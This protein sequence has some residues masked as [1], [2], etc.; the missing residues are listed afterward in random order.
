MISKQIYGH[1][2]TIE[3][4]YNHISWKYKSHWVKNMFLT[5]YDSTELWL[6]EGGWC[7][8]QIVT[9]K[10]WM[11]QSNLIASMSCVSQPLLQLQIDKPDYNN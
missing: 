8:T 7:T 11:S 6:R 1:S 9:I 2:F 4:R 3:I 5:E 10:L